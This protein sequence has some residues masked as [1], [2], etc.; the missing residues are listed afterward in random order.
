MIATAWRLGAHQQYAELNLRR[1]AHMLGFRR[2]F[3]TKSRAYSV[4]FGAIRAERRT[5]HLRAV[6][7][8][9]TDPDDPDP[10]PVDL[11][12]VTVV[13]DWVVVRFGHRTPL[14]R[15][16]AEAIAERNRNRRRNR[17]AIAR[18]VAA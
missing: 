6:N 5:S 15:E 2:H 4:T 14:E 18:E 9:L 3:L 10:H 12:T 8:E 13:N 1:W 11:D 16:L 17:I 7:D